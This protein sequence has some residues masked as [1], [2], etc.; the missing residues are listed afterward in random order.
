MLPFT[1]VE[2]E[3]F[4]NIFPGTVVPSADTV[5]RWMEEM[6]TERKKEIKSYLKKIDV[7]ISFTFDMWT[8]ISNKSYLGLI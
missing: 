4:H 5:K 8:S 2:A 1:I 6:F 7:P 3:T